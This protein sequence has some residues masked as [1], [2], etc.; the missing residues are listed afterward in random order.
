M[1]GLRELRAVLAM[2][3]GSMAHVDEIIFRVDSGGTSGKAI[4]PRSAKYLEILSLS[5]V[6]IEHAKD[7]LQ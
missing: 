4:R 6:G 5:S 7:C 1:H 3:S 2:Q